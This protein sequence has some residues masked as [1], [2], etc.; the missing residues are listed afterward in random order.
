MSPFGGQDG[1][2]QQSHGGLSAAAGARLVIQ[3]DHTSPPIKWS[4]RQVPPCLGPHGVRPEHPG[5]GAGTRPPEIS[6]LTFS[7]M[8]WGGR[9]KG[10]KGLGL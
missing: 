3:E 1:A 10:D 9:M 7:T 5:W 2:A 4:G 8:R 6:P